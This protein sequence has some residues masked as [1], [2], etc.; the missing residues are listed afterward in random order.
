MVERRKKVFGLE[1]DLMAKRGK[2]STRAPFFF[3][4]HSQSRRMEK[5]KDHVAEHFFA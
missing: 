3:E 4:C 1:I 5:S 2:N